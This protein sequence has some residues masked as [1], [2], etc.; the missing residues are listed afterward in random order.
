MNSLLK[1]IVDS[2]MAEYQ[3]RKIELKLVTKSDR[4]V[5]KADPIH[6]QMVFENLVNNAQK[7]SPDGTKVTVTVG[8]DPKAVTVK[9]KD[10]GIGIAA[11]DIPVL[12]RKFSRIENVNSM[13]SGTGLG[14]YW[15]KK[16][17]EL[18]GGEIRVSSKLHEGTTFSV[19]IP[20]AK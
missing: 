13:A 14:L 3:R 6:L 12:F 2:Q 10:Q 7:Y 11:A 9:V 17:A 18:H 8:A 4:A 15:A 5:V 16:L 20:R 19:I 1:R